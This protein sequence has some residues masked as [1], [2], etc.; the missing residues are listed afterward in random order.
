MFPTTKQVV[1]P[2]L[3]ASFVL[4]LNQAPAFAQRGMMPMSQRM[5]PMMSP[6]PL[7]QM[8]TFSGLNGN[9]A[10]PF[11]TG[12]GNFS[13]ST[14]TNPFSTY[15]LGNGSQGFGGYGPAYGVMSGYGGYGMGYGMGGYGGYGGYGQGYGMG[16]PGLY[17]MPNVAGYSDTPDYSSRS[18]KDSSADLETALKEAASKPDKLSH[19]EKAANLRKRLDR[20]LYQPN[21][22]DKQKSGVA[23]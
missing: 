20:Y 10:T 22:E 14:S 1:R 4:A 7:S 17:S 11:S 3:L 8:P 21:D 5:M 9:G 18:Y 23:P 19:A 6:A 2:I 16:Q 13:A 15:G 12:N